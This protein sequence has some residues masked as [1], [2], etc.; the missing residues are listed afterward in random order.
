[1]PSIG[2]GRQDDVL[3]SPVLVDLGEAVHL[4]GAPVTFPKTWVL[5]SRWMGPRGLYSAPTRS[6]LLSKW[7]SVFFPVE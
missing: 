2:I 6:Q 4:D 5:D 3:Q 7:N 1:L